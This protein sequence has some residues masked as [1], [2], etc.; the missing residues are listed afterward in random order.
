MFAY[1][2]GILSEISDDGVIIEVNGIGYNILMPSN[3]IY[4]LSDIGNEVKL[5]TYTCVRE[6]AFSLYGFI[7]ND[8]L[9]LFKLLITVSGIGPK[10]AMSILSVMNPSDVVSAILTGDSKFISSAPGVGKKTAER[11]ILEL[12][13]KIQ[14]MDIGYSAEM[15]NGKRSSNNEISDDAKD[16]IDALTALGY[17]NVEAKEA[18]LK[19]V[20][21]NDANSEDIL[22]N[23]LKYL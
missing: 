17:S 12:Q 23:A 13:D 21:S 3:K 20:S 16:A 11:V 1:F 4:E 6:D 15:F 18:V 5:Y 2:K 8:E 19:A 7:T 9:K 22:K 10:G 14:K